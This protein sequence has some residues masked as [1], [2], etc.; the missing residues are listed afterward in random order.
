[1]LLVCKAMH[2]QDPEYLNELLIPYNPQGPYAPSNNMLIVP[3]CHYADTEKRAFGV[4]AP[5]MWNDLPRS[6]REK[7]SLE[8]FK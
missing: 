5:K 7:D 3:R 1:M 2:G 8:M 4:C 6:V